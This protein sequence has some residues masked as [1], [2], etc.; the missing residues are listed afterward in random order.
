MVGTLEECW[1]PWSERLANAAT[2]MTN[3]EHTSFYDPNYNDVNSQLQLLSSIYDKHVN[4]L[5]EPKIETLSSKIRDDVM[6]TR[7]KVSGI[8]RRIK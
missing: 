3:M 5:Q 2:Y 4:S 8:P 7:V 1:D 6:I